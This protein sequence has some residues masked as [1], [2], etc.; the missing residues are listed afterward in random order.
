MKSSLSLIAVDGYKYVRTKL[1]HFTNICKLVT[2]WV[3]MKLITTRSLK[4][5]ILFD[6]ASNVMLSSLSVL[7]VSSGTGIK[8]E[9]K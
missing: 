6:F 7:S 5:A 8:V 4:P 2:K 1:W 3:T 9:N